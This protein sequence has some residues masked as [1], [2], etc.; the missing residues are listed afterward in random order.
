M[1]IKM[2]PICAE[3]IPNRLHAGEYCG[4]LSRR[5]NKTEICSECGV[6]EAI[7]DFNS[8]SPFVDELVKGVLLSEFGGEG[9]WKD[10]GIDLGYSEIW[11]PISFTECFMEVEQYDM[12]LSTVDRVANDGIFTRLSRRDI[13]NGVK[14]TAIADGQVRRAWRDGVKYGQYFFTAE[15]GNAI[16]LM[17]VK[18]ATED[19]DD[20][21][22]RGAELS[23]LHQS[24]DVHS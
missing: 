18:M 9:G 23:A 6:M 11:H 1:E 2:C 22:T 4:A 3:P 16:M 15:M 21:D 17:A 24:E 12:N 14:W 19:G 7:E 13:V 10:V 20:G 8:K 5:D